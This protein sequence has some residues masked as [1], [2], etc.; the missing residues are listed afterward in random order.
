VPGLGGLRG[1]TKN[2]EKRYQMEGVITAILNWIITSFGL[3]HQQECKDH[4]ATIQHS[5]RMQEEFYKASL[6]MTVVLTELKT[7]LL[8][9]PRR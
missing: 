2:G 3:L 6:S 4:D 7:A 8:C 5:R 9:K 1:G